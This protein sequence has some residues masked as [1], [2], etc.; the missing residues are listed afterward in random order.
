V[1]VGKADY[2]FKDLSAKDAR[3]AAKEVM[4][5][6]KDKDSKTSVADLVAAKM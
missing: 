4:N 5:E 6:I 3:Q 2:P 1:G